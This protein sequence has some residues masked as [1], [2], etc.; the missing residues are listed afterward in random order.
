MLDPGFCA[1]ISNAPLRPSRTCLAVTNKPSG[2]ILNAVPTNSKHPGP[3]TTTGTITEFILVSGISTNES[4]SNIMPCA[5]GNSDPI[6]HLRLIATGQPIPLLWRRLNR[7]NST[8]SDS[9][10]TCLTRAVGSKLA[11]VGR[12]TAG[13]DENTQGSGPIAIRRGQSSVAFAVSAQARG[14]VVTAVLMIVVGIAL[15]AGL[16]SLLMRLD[17]ASRQRIERRREA[18]RAWGRVGPGPGAAAGAEAAAAAAAAATAA[19]AEAAEAAAAEA[20]ETADS[21][22]NRPGS[23]HA[24]AIIEAA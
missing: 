11:A 16:I 8:G 18:W 5:D 24:D 15:V 10:Q 12:I 14:C 4:L 1:R 9:Q 2:A 3:I 13:Y 7:P 21:G 19:E 22:T 20:A 23:N 17:R 6:T